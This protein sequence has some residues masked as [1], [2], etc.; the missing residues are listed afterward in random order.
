MTTK[1]YVGN[2]SFTTT[3]KDLQDLF[4]TAGL[5]REAAVIQDRDTG[6]SRGFAFVTMSS[7][8][9]ARNAVTR[10]HGSAF[11]G[12]NLTVNEAKPRED[13]RAHSSTRRY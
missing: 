12:R 5:V 1:L 13:S 8:A 6:K 3:G 4:S 7:D 10:F 2:L 11:Q 9:D